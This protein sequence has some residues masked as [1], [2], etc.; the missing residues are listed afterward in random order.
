MA[1]CIYVGMGGF[2]GS[3][4]RYLVSLIPLKTTHG[5]PLLTLFINILGAFLIGFISTIALKKSMNPHLVLLLK[6]GLCRG[7]TT[8]STFALESITLHKNGNTTLA[9][10]YIVLSIVLGPSAVILGDYCA[11]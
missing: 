8:F 10:I 9:M 3:V 6:T 1:A 4:L 11:H 5:F 2:I 7:F